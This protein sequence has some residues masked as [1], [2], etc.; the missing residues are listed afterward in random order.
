[1][2]GMRRGDD[3][4]EFE[5]VSRD[6]NKE[7]CDSYCCKML[8]KKIEFLFLGIFFL[9]NFARIRSED[10]DATGMGCFFG[11]FLEAFQRQGF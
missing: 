11:S 9:V 2:K 6:A 3:G 1:M 7:R 5:L 4:H 8:K 10:R